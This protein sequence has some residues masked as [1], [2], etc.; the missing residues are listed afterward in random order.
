MT[1]FEFD[2]DYC[3]P[4]GATLRE[5]IVCR[6][7]DAMAEACLWLDLDTIELWNFFDGKLPMS[8]YMARR[9]ELLTLVSKP[10]WLAREKRYR[11]G[12]AK[13]LKVAT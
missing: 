11:E 3:V 13:G 12:L 8:E 10:F 6:D 7:G 9:L 4:P 1:D 5:W 2:P